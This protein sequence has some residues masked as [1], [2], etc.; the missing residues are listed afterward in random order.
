MKIKTLR[1]GKKEYEDFRDLQ[2][3]HRNG[4]WA[5]FSV[6]SDERVWPFVCF[7][8]TPEEKRQYVALDQYP[9]VR[10]VAQNF[11]SNVDEQGGRFFIKQDGVYGI[12][13]E[14]EPREI[15]QQFV[16]WKPDDSL[17]K[18]W[19]EI[20]ATFALKNFLTRARR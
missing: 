4:W 15:S 18:H 11:I 1:I 6:N 12:K 8:L 19:T 9:R 2:I 13:G 20:N 5:V 3:K 16:N 17:A 7:G 14:N 10:E